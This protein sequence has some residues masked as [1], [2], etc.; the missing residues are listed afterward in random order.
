MKYLNKFVEDELECVGDIFARG[1]SE[2]VGKLEKQLG[3]RCKVFLPVV[4]GLSG[5]VGADSV[6][7][8]S[9]SVGKVNAS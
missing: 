1:V 3:G 7:R 2:K 4:E 9:E 6:E 8:V 5:W